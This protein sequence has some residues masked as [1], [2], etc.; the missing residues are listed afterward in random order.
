M[1]ALKFKKKI[2]S[3]FTFSVK[4]NKAVLPTLL[5][6][7]GDLKFYLAKSAFTK[8]YPHW[9]VC[10]K[11]VYQLYSRF[12]L[13]VKSRKLLL[14]TLLYLYADNKFHLRKSTFTNLYAQWKGCVKFLNQLYADLQQISV[15]VNLNFHAVKAL[16]KLITRGRKAFVSRSVIKLSQ[17]VSET[18]LLKH[19]SGMLE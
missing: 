17:S 11:F 7:Y 19:S 16:L 5:R 3:R 4:L 18:L 15:P 6:L 1:K 13:S 12:T 8:F 10:V 2:Y 9:K 14:P